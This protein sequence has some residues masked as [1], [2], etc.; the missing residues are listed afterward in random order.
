MN[1]LRKHSND[2]WALL[3]LLILPLLWFGPVLFPTLSGQTLLP[4]DNLYTFEP[5]RS[6]QPNLLPYNDLL[7]DLVLENAVW[8][9]HIRQTLADGQLPLWNPQ[10][11]TG[12]PF[13]AAGQASTFYPLSV[14][15]YL[16]PLEA[17]YAWFT[18]LQ[19]ALAG[20]NMYIFGR[21]LGL[22][23]LAALLSSVVYM[24]SGFLIV[25]VVFTMFIAAVPWLPLLLAVIEFMIRKQEDKGAHSFSP[26]PYIIIGVIIIGLTI[27]AGHPEMIYYTLL[28][29]AAYSLFRLIVAWRRIHTLTPVIQLGGWL[30]FMAILGIA[31]GGIQLLPLL[32][33]LPLNFREG[34]ASYNQIVEW[35]WPDRH[36]LTFFLPDVFGNPSHHHWF[37]LWNQSW[38]P[39]TTN[40]LGE[41]NHTIFWG[42]KN[43]V[44]GGNYLGIGSWLLVV[45][46]WW[47]VAR[48][49]G[50][51]AGRQKQFTLFF[52]ILALIS[53]L[54]AFGTPLYKLLFYGL[55]GWNQLH[56]PFRWVF[57]FTLSMA[58]LGGIGLQLLLDQVTSRDVKRSFTVVNLLPISAV[59]AGIAILAVVAASLFM[60]EPFIQLAQRVVDSSDLAQFTFTDGRMFWGYQSL[61]LIKLGGWLLIAGLLVWG[62][63]RTRNAK[64]AQW[65]AIALIA[66]VVL[67]LY[68]VHGRF[69]PASDITLSP[70][71]AE[72]Q[73][74]VVAF[75]NQHDPPDGNQPWRFTTFNRPGEK[76][77]NA[78]VGMYYG[79]HDIRGYD[80]VIPRQYVQFMD[81]IAP[82]ENELLYNRIAPLYS[83]VAAYDIL[84][85]PLLDLLNVKYVLTEHFI[86]NPT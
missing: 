56:S 35:A 81:R 83:N 65:L 22:R 16:L 19:I 3:T 32:E 76:T 15:F 29:A 31:S 43:Y 34:S 51:G 9:Q 26:I 58:V 75:L 38:M 73:P 40:A 5:W 66:C 71:I 60:P 52:S 62:L 46:G 18:A 78:N 55:P 28:V 4:Y 8:K 37:D 54:F 12:L 70:T 67:D 47:L 44:E 45:G 36:I 23:S 33:L 42:I 74:P 84:D 63:A 7:S 77:L 86:P 10:I 2:L 79:W 48:G 72:N 17:A 80:S 61:N 14:L 39:A 21:V 20:I 85:N 24:F 68:S 11:F 25:S 57:P 49:W 53:L 64:T 30:I 27:L 50:L 13:L 69:N 82:Q 1:Q 41:P 6:L 59:L